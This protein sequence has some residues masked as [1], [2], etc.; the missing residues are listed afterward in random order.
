MVDVASGVEKAPG[1]KDLAR[2]E[3]FI[4]AARSVEVSAVE[5]PEPAARSRN[6]LPGGAAITTG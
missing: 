6:D 4:K 3:A 1:R 2:V 5:A